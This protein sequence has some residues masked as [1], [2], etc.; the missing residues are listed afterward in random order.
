VIVE[1]RPPHDPLQELLVAQPGITGARRAPGRVDRALVERIVPSLGCRKDAGNEIAVGVVPQA[2]PHLG[3]TDG[4]WRGEEWNRLPL[5]DQPV[6]QRSVQLRR[7][8]LLDGQ[9]ER[10]PHEGGCE[11]GQH[12]AEADA[13]QAP[14]AESLVDV[15]PL[16]R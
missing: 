3:L 15:E 10:R 9:R 13:R 6:D 16:Q 2:A 4:E 14:S 8:A 12:L 5:R 11:E 1:Q 7:P